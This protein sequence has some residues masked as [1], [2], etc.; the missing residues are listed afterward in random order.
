MI[1][2]GLNNQNSGKQMR[3]DK[4]RSESPLAHLNTDGSDQALC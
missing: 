3:R 4:G 1:T 2:Q